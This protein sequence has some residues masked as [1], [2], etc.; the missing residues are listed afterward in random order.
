MGRHPAMASSSQG[1]IVGFWGPK[2]G[3][4]GLGS[5]GHLEG[6]MWYLAYRGRLEP[7]GPLGRITRVPRQAWTDCADSLPRGPR[8]TRK[9]GKSPRRAW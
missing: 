1:E 3:V 7:L 6:T 5:H 9:L 8:S 2:R 4:M